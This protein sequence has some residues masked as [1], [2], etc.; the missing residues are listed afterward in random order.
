[1]LEGFLLVI[2]FLAL[3]VLVGGMIL[4]AIFGIEIFGVSIGDMFNWVT[5][6]L[7]ALLAVGFVLVIGVAVGVGIQSVVFA[8]A[9]GMLEAKPTVLRGLIATVL[10]AVVPGLLFYTWGEY[11]LVTVAAVI[12]FIG[13]LLVCWMKGV[14]ASDNKTE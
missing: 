1:M 13:P 14:E 10:L 3:V 5:T 4:N 6:E 7:P 12:M 8:F 2:C 11:M 9:T